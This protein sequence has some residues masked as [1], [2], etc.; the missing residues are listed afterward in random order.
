[1]NTKI[2]FCHIPKTGGYSLLNWFKDDLK[3]YEYNDIAR[4]QP[5]EQQLQD[6][7]DA[8]IIEIHG[9]SPQSI[10]HLRNATPEAHE[11]Y[12]SIIRNPIE[13]FESLCRDAYIHKAYLDL[14]LV[15]RR[16]SSNDIESIY[17][18][19][20]QNLDFDIHSFYQIYNQYWSSIHPSLLV[21][22][23]SKLLKL[24]NT[25][26]AKSLNSAFN[27]S[28]LFRR[29]G[30]SKYL[31]KTFG[32]HFLQEVF[33]QNANYILL[34]TEQLEKQFI[35]LLLSNSL[36]KSCTI[37]AEYEGTYKISDI[38][39]KLKHARRNITPNI[40]NKNNLKLDTFESYS[41]TILNQSDY[42][43]WHATT[44]QW[45]NRLKT[46]NSLL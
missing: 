7:Q 22:N 27:P 5:F 9:G 23:E 36:F 3:I 34:T 31:I 35:W 45:N 15:S 43:I 14:P 30:Q 41:Y 16:F 38:E 13:Q 20:Y 12:I 18:E 21:D 17:E 11:F 8:A 39:K 6:Y 19:E 25:Y 37:F 1:M 28:Y 33:T 4:S 42:N 26:V 24:V 10:D 29:N 32:T 46:L 2:I 44:C 40:G